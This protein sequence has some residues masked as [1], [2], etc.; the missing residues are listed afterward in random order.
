M[1]VLSA[2][3]YSARLNYSAGVEMSGNWPVFGRSRMRIRYSVQLYLQRKAYYLR[4]KDTDTVISLPVIRTAML[5][6]DKSVHGKQCDR[7]RQKTLAAVIYGTGWACWILHVPRL[8]DAHNQRLEW[9]LSDIMRWNW[10][11]KYGNLHNK[12]PSWCWQQARRV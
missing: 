9:L 10:I 5:G 2:G 12:K 1:H 7:P 6:S 3:G 8:T 11:F 4:S